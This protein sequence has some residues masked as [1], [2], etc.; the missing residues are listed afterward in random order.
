MNAARFIVR[1]TV[2]G[3]WF[4]GAT[5]ERAL[6][7]GL[8]GIAKNLADGSVEV[9]AIG[10]PESIA[11]LERWLWQGPPHADVEHVAREDL[12][13]IPVSPGFHTA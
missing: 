8:D 6:E 5:R 1:G 3:V 9:L 4:R 10:A 13:E 11:L 7:L 2:Q 12:D